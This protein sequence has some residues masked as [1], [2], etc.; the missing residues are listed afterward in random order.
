LCARAIRRMIFDIRKISLPVDGMDELCNEARSEGYEFID[1]LVREWDSGVNRFGATGE[2]LCGCIENERIIAI[3][4][5]N[6]DPFAARA[7][8]GR[9]RRVYVRAERRGCGV[10][11]ALVARLIEEARNSFMVVRLRAVS[12]RAAKFYERLGFE[13]LEDASATHSLLLSGLAD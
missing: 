11:E 10:G 6:C 2:A 4:G 5:L 9:I 12:P 8:V 7:E 3:G 1:R 13:P